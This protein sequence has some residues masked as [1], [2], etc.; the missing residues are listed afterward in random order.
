MSNG[1]PLEQF[2]EKD[3]G[4]RMDGLIRIERF[5]I[6]QGTKSAQ[7]WGA[8][9]DIKQLVKAA[10]KYNGAPAEQQATRPAQNGPSFEDGV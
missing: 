9:Y 10:L 2:W 1:I 8:W 3:D 6:S 4:V 5:I 7:I